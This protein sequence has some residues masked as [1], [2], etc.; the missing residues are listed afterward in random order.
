MQ[1]RIFIRRCLIVALIAFFS[2]ESGG[3]SIN[4]PANPGFADAVE[5][6]IKEWE[7][8][9]PGSHPHDPAVAPDGAAWYTGQN[10]N[11]LGRLDYRTGRFRE[12]PLPTPRSGPH[13][14]VADRDGAIWYT[15][16]SAALIG[17]LD[18]VTGQVTEYRMTDPRARDPHTPIFDQQGILWFTVQNG[19]LIGRLEPSTGKVT[20]VESKTPNSR[21]Y[22]IV[23][24]S[25]GV[26]FFDLFGTNK[27]GSINPAT[28]EITEYVLPSGARPRR[29]DVTP[30][31]IVWYT[32]YARGYLGRLD[33]RTGVVT[34]FSSPAGRSS[35]PYGIAATSDGVIWY[36]E[37]G[38]QPNTIV[39]FDPARGSFRSWPIPSGGG[40]VRH[41]VAAPGNDVWIACSGV[42][43]LG[44]VSAAL[45]VT[46]VPAASFAQ[47][48][49]APESIVAAF[50]ARLATVTEAA[51]TL[52][53]PSELGNTVVSVLD[54]A[55]ATR[56]APLFFVSPA[57]VNYL[58]PAGTANGAATVTISSGDGSASIG[59]AQI[60]AV[61]PGLFAANADGQ[62]AAAATVLRVRADNSQIYEPPAAV[63]DTAQNR[64][65]AR[66][67]NLGPESDRVFLILFG[68]GFRFRSA[69][70]AVSV[71]I[72]G[73]DSTV[74][75][76]GA[77]G[78]FAGLDQ[79]NVLLPR[80]LAG[81]GEV[82]IVLMVEGRS[83][84]RV[85]VRIG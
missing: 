47:G 44:R 41:M 25:K 3:A 66:E 46:S 30:D 24:N 64:F 27:I 81:R 83:A 18:P 6:G 1:K 17:K 49:I 13:G 69:L 42:N 85:V 57:Q 35:Q 63:F 56:A 84:N 2:L 23:V 19:N 14:L 37:S 32:D 78:D 20:L 71:K 43:K 55:G 34:E 79:I 48:E 21:P 45:P 54:S 4:G 62:G 15:G 31:D 9:T 50:G 70:S 10:T 38:V 12:Y 7:V 26:P 51:S 73:V 68:S 28:M 65:V 82:E 11:T 52:P 61:S 33:P 16:N 39:R 74:S 53:L 72:G 77:Q 59:A 80:S 60:S 8:P 40:V 76:A 22:G 5:I 67:I 58:I 36:S 75:F 29:I